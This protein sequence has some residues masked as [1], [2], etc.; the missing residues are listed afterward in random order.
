MNEYL[1]GDQL[2]R[3]LHISKRKMKY[4]LENG[5]I[6]ANIAGTKTHRYQIRLEDA[7]AFKQRM[8]KRPESL[9]GL[10]GKF[11]SR[12][13]KPKPPLMEPTKE[14]CRA[15]REYLTELWENQPDALPTQLAAKLMG[16]Q[17][18]L[19]HTLVRSSRLHGVK[20]GSVQYCPKV[21]F[22]A[23]AASP[24]KISRPT[25]EV[26]RGLIRAFIKL[27]QSRKNT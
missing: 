26:Y 16:C 5:Y 18:Q 24:E 25:S 20:I 9:A 14:N 2:Y 22:I 8:K 19:L 10:T 17:P 13:S 3:Y 1:S 4:L 6:P 7:S 15:F 11:N 21:E 27:Q 23:H 12:P